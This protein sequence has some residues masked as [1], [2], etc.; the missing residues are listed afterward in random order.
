MHPNLL[1]PTINVAK[2][3]K[4]AKDISQL[5]HQSKIQLI[6]LKL[7]DLVLNEVKHYVQY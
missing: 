7:N 4:E 3:E 5:N 6:Q 2:K 1:R